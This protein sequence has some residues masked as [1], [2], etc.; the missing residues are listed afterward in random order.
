MP[1]GEKA[2]MLSLIKF[3]ALPILFILSLLFLLDW[4]ERFKSLKGKSKNLVRFITALFFSFLVS[5][6]FY[7]YIYVGLIIFILILALKFQVRRFI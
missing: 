6:I 2:C 3:L 7:L 4:L 1:Q 5:Y